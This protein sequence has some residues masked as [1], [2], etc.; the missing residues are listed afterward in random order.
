M[1]NNTGRMGFA[2][3]AISVVAFVL[4]AVNG[5]LKASASG[6]FTG[7]QSFQKATMDKIVGNDDPTPS[8]PKPDANDSKWIQ[9][10]NYGT[11]GYF[12]MDADGNGIVYALDDSKPIT[13]NGV[14]AQTQN[15]TK[16]T[17]LTFL[18]KVIGSG[19]L[20]KFFQGDKSLLSIEGLDK[21]NTSNVSAM[22][23]MFDSTGVQS[24]DLSSWD[25]SNVEYFTA[26]FQGMNAMSAL[27]VSGWNTKS[28]IDM[29]SMFRNT[30]KL[31][32]LDV[33]SFN[34]S[35]VSNMS[36]MFQSSGVTSLDL[37]KWNVSNVTDMSRMM[38]MAS[39]K[40]LNMSNWNLNKVSNM[41]L[42]FE[43]SKLTSVSMSDIVKAPSTVN[44]GNMFRN[45][46]LS[47]SL[48][49]SITNGLIS[50]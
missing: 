32:N 34:T 22:D 17:K 43:G 40:T 21:W 14:Q 23:Y 31:V 15:N 26:M 27:N 41:G 36:M 24:L 3:I 46:Q 33:Q 49:T 19:Y 16:L 11:N 29:S 37:S 42:M 47:S 9:K 30:Y 25:V 10:G 5:P 44:Q 4:L 13:V 35:N 2:L 12:V 18:N 7:L 20:S 48:Q 6:L 38:S 50:K 28:A 39:V 45:A 8:N 1:E